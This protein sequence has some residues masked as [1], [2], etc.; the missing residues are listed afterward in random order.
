MLAAV[1]RILTLLSPGVPAP[2]CSLQLPF[3][4]TSRS[5]FVSPQNL[6]SS[7]FFFFFS[8]LPPSF[9][10]KLHGIFNIY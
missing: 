4:L 9:S 7:Y 3:S 10:L 5:I 2:G 8:I 6:L 1:L